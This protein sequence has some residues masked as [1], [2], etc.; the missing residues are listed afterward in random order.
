MLASKTLLKSI[1]NKSE[2][3]QKRCQ[4][5]DTFF[6]WFFIDFG[7]VMGPKLEACW[8][9]VGP[10]TLWPQKGV[11]KD[12]REP[13]PPALQSFKTLIFFSWDRRGPPWG[14]P[15]PPGLGKQ[16]ALQTRFPSPRLYI[17]IYIY[18]YIYDGFCKVSISMCCFPCGLTVYLTGV[19]TAAYGKPT[20]LAEQRTCFLRPCLWLTM[21]T[22][23]AQPNRYL[24]SRRVTGLRHTPVCLREP[25]GVFC[26]WEIGFGMQIKMILSRLRYILR[27]CLRQLTARQPLS[28]FL[29]HFSAWQKT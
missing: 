7:R 10:E 16:G 5:Y 14:R 21:V 11:A 4:K 23:S 24:R 3:C 20:P 1:K 12:A 9:Y 13:A 29:D 19:L 8:P 28:H 26:D 22:I 27:A 25:Y 15:V 6:N 17:Y 2:I 18:I